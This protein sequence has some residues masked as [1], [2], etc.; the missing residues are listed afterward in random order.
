MTALNDEKEKTFGIR[1]SLLI[2]AVAGIGFNLYYKY[3][4]Y[5]LGEALI[6][7][8]I[9]VKNPPEY[10]ETGKGGTDRYILDGEAYKC[11]FWISEGGLSIVRDNDRIEHEIKNI[12]T[13]ETI[14]LKVRQ[15]DEP[16]VQD[17]S[18]RLRVIE[19]STSR[20]KLI[21]AI[22][23]EAKD[24]KSY[25]INFGLPIAALMIWLVIQLRKLLKGKKE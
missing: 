6:E 24:R 17:E 3:D 13:G 19:L 15:A 10:V 20:E 5:Y 7:K 4:R 9:I 8:Q 21:S 25:K 14:I 11:R 16:R 22:D 1:T 18:A 23:V 12:K 2:I